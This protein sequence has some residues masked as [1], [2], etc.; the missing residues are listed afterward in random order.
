[1]KLYKGSVT[2]KRPTKYTLKVQGI[3]LADGP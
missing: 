3:S 1:M 2:S